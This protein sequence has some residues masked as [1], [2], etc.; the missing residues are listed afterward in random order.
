MMVVYYDAKID[1]IF[2]RTEKDAPFYTVKPR[3]FERVLILGLL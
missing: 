1:K 3:E 2:I